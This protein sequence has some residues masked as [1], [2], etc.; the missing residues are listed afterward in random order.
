MVSSYLVRDK[1]HPIERKVGSSKGNA[2]RCEECKN[3]LQT[4]MFT[5]SNDKSTLQNKS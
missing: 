5:C 4:D 1:L 3:V 2:K